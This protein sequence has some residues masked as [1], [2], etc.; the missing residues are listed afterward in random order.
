MTSDDD[1]H[2]E[3]EQRREHLVRLLTLSALTMLRCAGPFW[4]NVLTAGFCESALH[5]RRDVADHIIHMP[6]L[7]E[8]S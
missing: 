5:I 4:G 1:L 3:D 7:K 2:P 6:I 8:M